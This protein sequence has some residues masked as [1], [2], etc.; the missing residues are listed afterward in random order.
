MRL[1]LIGCFVVGC[2]SWDLTQP[3]APPRIDIPDSV[4]A[5]SEHAGALSVAN[6]QAAFADGVGQLGGTVEPFGQQ[7]VRFTYVDTCC[8]TC[9]INTVAFHSTLHD[10]IR[11]C[12]YA[13]QQGPEV[14]DAIVKHEILH[15]FTNRGDHLACET[16]ATMSPKTNCQSH[17]GQ[18]TAADF[19]YLCRA[20]VPSRVCVANRD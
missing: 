14:I 2:G 10:D 16:G 11:F 4:F 6:I 5:Q 18:Y 9:P 17:L 15:L 13:L 3:F 12:P 20:G 19:N 1:A 7:R 8:A